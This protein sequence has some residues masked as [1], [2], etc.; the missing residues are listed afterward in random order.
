ML[1]ESHLERYCRK[2]GGRTS[3]V[4]QGTSKHGGAARGCCSPVSVSTFPPALRVLVSVAVNLKS[5]KQKQTKK[6]ALR[7]NIYNFIKQQ[8]IVEG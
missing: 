2:K 8:F 3:D 1:L 7:Y 5:A 6:T 4:F